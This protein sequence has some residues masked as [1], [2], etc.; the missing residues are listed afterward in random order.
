[1]R[2][3][4]TALDA[5]TEYAGPIINGTCC[6]SSGARTRKPSRTCWHTMLLRNHRRR[7]QD[8][9]RHVGSDTQPDSASATVQTRPGTKNRRLRAVSAA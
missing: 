9:A 4:H 8:P 1:M 3:L 5:R 6:T 2:G 7:S